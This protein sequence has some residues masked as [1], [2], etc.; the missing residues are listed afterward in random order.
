[1]KELEEI[2]SYIYQNLVSLLL[3]M[4]PEYINFYKKSSL[5]EDFAEG[6]VY[7]FMNK[8]AVHLASEIRGD[9][10]SSF[11]KNAFS[12]INVLYEI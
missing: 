6:G 2:D 9:T 11:V 8:F 10:N 4:V 7:L 5:T 3:K 1:M 12:Y